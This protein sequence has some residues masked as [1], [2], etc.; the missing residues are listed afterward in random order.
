MGKI[1]R[2]IKSV[3]KALKANNANTKKMMKYGA[4]P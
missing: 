3:G 4:R 2:A 1:T